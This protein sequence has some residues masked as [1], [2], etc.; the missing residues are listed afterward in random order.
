MGTFHEMTRHEHGQYASTCKKVW[1]MTLWA[2]TVREGLLE[3]VGLAFGVEDGRG[4]KGSE[5][6][7]V[8]RAHGGLKPAYR[9][10]S[11]TLCRYKN[12]WLAGCAGSCL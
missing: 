6:S 3:E 10:K 8:C 7:S 12:A 5:R 2:V 9:K 1:G 11:H 4:K